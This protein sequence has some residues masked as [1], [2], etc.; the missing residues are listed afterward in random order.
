MKK[1]LFTKPKVITFYSR[2]EK[3]KFWKKNLKYFYQILPLNE[4]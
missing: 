1:K 4:I 2:M 3:H